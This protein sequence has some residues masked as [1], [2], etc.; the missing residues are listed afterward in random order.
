MCALDIT[1][2]LIAFYGGRVSDV[3][4]AEVTRMDKIQ[5][6]FSPFTCFTSPLFPSALCRC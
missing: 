1:A 4:T 6:P 3:L 5:L 2:R